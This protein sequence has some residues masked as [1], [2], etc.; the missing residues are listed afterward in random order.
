MAIKKT[1]TK[2]TAKTTAARRTTAVTA[3]APVTAN[4]RDALLKLIQLSIKK[5]GP[6]CDLNFINVSK[7]K[8]MRGR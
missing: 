1:E 2:K 7:I 8:D 3:P 6:K 5:Y 4:D